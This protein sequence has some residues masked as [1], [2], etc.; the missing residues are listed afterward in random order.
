MRSWRMDDMWARILRTGPSQGLHD[1]DGSNHRQRLRR[2]RQACNRAAFASPPTT[3]LQSVTPK[4]ATL[5]AANLVGPCV[6]RTWPHRALLAIVL[7]DHS[8]MIIVRD[9]RWI[10]LAHPRRLSNSSCVCAC[11]SASSARVSSCWGTH[12]GTE[13]ASGACRA[14][15]VIW[16]G[17]KYVLQVVKVVDGGMLPQALHSSDASSL[18]HTHTHATEYLRWDVRRKALMEVVR[19]LDADILCLQVWSL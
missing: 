9:T 12:R 8:F 13:E 15:P 19:E 16:V 7:G 2:A 17:Q 1:A 3:Y 10:L 11:V 18:H 4:L 14:C 6:M 5:P